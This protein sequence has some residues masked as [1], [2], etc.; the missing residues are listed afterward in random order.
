MVNASGNEPSAA[1]TMTGCPALAPLTIAVPDVQ[2]PAPSAVP[3]IG[4]VV[5]VNNP[6]VM[7][8]G[9]EM[10]GIVPPETTIGVL[11]V[12]PTTQV[13]HE[14]LGPIPPVEAKGAAATTEVTQ[15][16]QDRLGAVPPLETRGEAPVTAVTVPFA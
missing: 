13:G 14:I 10:F 5:P 9:Q 11:L 8:V 2:V 1:L 4:P 16:G 3:P 12:T 15:V 6:L 7:H